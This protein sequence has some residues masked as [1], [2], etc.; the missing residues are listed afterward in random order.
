MIIGISGKMGTGKTTLA[1]YLAE[2]CG[3]RVASFADELRDEVACTFDIQR[4][5]M[6]VRSLKENMLV[7]VGYQFMTL[8]QLLQWW[9]GLRRESDPDYWVCRLLSGVDPGELVLVDDVRYRNEAAAIR[10]AG[11]QVIRLD[12]YDGWQRGVGSDHLSETDLDDGF[13]FDWRSAPAFGEL[14]PL[15]NQLAGLIG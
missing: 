2:Q 6:L 7:P 13:A 10:A 9:G 12:P 14:W 1:N 3:G 11:G 5:H 4:G 15:A 8:R